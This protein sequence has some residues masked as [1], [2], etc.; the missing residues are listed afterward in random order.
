MCG[1]GLP[2]AAACVGVNLIVA[3][4]ENGQGA[5]QIQEMEQFIVF[6]NGR[7][8]RV[9]GYSLSAWSGHRPAKKRRRLFFLRPS[10][11]S[12]LTRTLWIP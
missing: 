12:E 3:V 10:A 6:F 7:N 8:R 5:R 9:R 2:A 1:A 11:R 4:P